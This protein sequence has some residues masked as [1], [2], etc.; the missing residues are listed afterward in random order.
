MTPAD[1][2]LIQMSAAA[3][4]AHYYDQ[5]DVRD[6]LLAD[7]RG[8]AAGH[9]ER[10]FVLLDELAAHVAAPKVKQ[11]P[12]RW[13]AA[14]APGAPGI[15]RTVKVFAALAEDTGVPAEHWAKT[16]A[17]AASPEAQP[18]RRGAAPGRI[19]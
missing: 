17:L 1:E 7:D 3:L 14:V 19:F 5:H 18:P 9:I 15:E 8:T 11:E 10:A 4:I 2:R 16:F 12:E 6:R 13:L